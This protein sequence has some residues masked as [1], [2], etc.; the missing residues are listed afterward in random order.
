MDKS[1]VISGKLLKDVQIGT[2]SDRCFRRYIECLLLAANEGAGGYLPETDEAAWL[3]HTTTDELETDLRELERR[4]LFEEVELTEWARRWYTPYFKRRV[5]L[6]SARYYFNKHR[7]SAYQALVER[8]GEYCRHCGK[9]KNLTVDHILA[10]ANGG[11]NE[12]ENLQLLCKSCNS[13]KGTK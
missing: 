11:G 6:E 13:R 3:L 7:K 2:L 9:T 1:V 5:E 8:D 10:I 12:L 4:G